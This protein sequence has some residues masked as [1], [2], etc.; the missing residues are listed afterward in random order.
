MKQQIVGILALAVMALL[1]F[2]TFASPV[3]AENE[4]NSNTV[5][6]NSPNMM[7]LAEAN[8]RMERMEKLKAFKAE[9]Q[10][11]INSLREKI[12]ELKEKY[13]ELKEQNKEITEELKN[14]FKAIKEQVHALKTEFRNTVGLPV[15]KLE[16]KR[17][18]RQEFL[19]RINGLL[20]NTSFTAEEKEILIHGLKEG[21]IFGMDGKSHYV[22]WTKSGDVSW[23]DFTDNHA[24]GQNLA[25]EKVNIFAA[26]GLFVGIEG[27]KTIWGNYANGFFGAY[28][29]GEAG[30]AEKMQTG[31]YVTYSS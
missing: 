6:E 14:E 13:H 15:Q 28:N 23:G 31:W 11:E 18:L 10:S 26:D 3:F 16:H 4:N 9:H 22:L 25:G 8:A 20:E 17:E 30:N 7:S 5:T 29:F 12:S 21:K 24:K 1:A 2:S 27:E 19:D